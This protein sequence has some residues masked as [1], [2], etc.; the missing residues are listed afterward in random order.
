MQTCVGYEM[1]M[2]SL[3]I[4]FSNGMQVRAEEE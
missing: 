3:G 4:I 2:E 1:C